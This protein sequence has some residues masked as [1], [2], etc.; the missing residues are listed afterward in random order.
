VEIPEF[1]DNH[2]V[3]GNDLYDSVQH[4]V[5]SLQAIAPRMT[6]FRARN[7]L[8]SGFSPADE[9]EVEDSFKGV[10][11]RWW[12]K[13]KAGEIGN[14][15]RRSYTLKL[16]KADRKFLSAYFN[17]VTRRAAEFITANKELTLYT[18]AGDA[19]YGDGWTGVPFKHSSTFA[20]L[21]LDPPLKHRILM[22]LDRFKQG[23]DFYGRIGR[24]W[25]RG[26]LLHGPPG[27]GK[28]SL[29]AAIANYM[30]YD[31]YDLELTRVKDN[32]ELRTLLTQTKEKSVIIIEDIDCSLDLTD[33]LSKPPQT[34]DSQDKEEEN[35]SKVTLS[36]LLNFTDG[37]WSCCGEERII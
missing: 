24:S 3:S 26:Y 35:I 31:V 23:R 16:P 13:T 33:R 36:G 11:V 29:V 12:H 17:H 19:C 18:N 14:I 10:R 34:E 4:Y 22:D 6:A 7:S 28:T 5:Q 32:T 25:K 8:N 20:S 27:T 37:L 2:G 9:E 30:K 15:E 21:A 1:K